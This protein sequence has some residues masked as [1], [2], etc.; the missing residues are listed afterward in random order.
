M[1]VLLTGGTGYIGAAVLDRVISRGHQVTAVVRS[2]EKAEL[3]R[4]K[5]T[6]P[7]VADLADATPWRNS[8]LRATA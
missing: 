3:V 6:E 8:R 4:A 1:R 2:P 7:A 5:G